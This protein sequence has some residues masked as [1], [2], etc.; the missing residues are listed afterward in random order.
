MMQKRGNVIIAIAIVTLLLIHG[1]VSGF[2]FTVSSQ[3]TTKEDQ[4]LYNGRIWK[5]LYYFVMEDQFLFSKTFLTGNI[6][7]NG[8]SYTG[9][10]LKYDLFKDELLTPAY[11]GI[12]LQLN[13]ELID[14]FSLSFENKIYRFIKMKG[15]S[16]NS[17]ASYYNVLYKGHSSVLVRYRKKIDKLAVEGKY[18]EFYPLTK[19]FLVKG[20][21][22]FPLSGKSDLLKAMEDKE[23]ELKVFIRKN[24]IHVTAKEPESFV[25]VVRYYD[26]LNQ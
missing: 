11:E 9:I 19:I 7:I 2:S 23:S 17:A 14:S 13:K 6:T 24:R 26:D 21:E 22:F 10:P 3:D 1:N 18:D 16:A 25:S 5:N 15:D 4:D 20:N 8:K 12:I